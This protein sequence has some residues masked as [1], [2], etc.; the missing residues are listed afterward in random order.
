IPGLSSG[1]ADPDGVVGIRVFSPLAVRPLIALSAPAALDFAGK[2]GGVN[3]PVCQGAKLT[4]A[5]FLGL[6]RLVDLHWNDGFVGVLHEILRQL[7]AVDPAFLADGVCHIFLLEQKVA[8]ISDISEDLPY[9]SVTEMLSLIGFYT[10]LGKLLFCGLRRQTV[11]VI[12]V[13]EPNDFCLLLMDDQRS[14]EH[15]SELQSRF[16]LVCR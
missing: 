6:H 3:A 11:H 12:V 13:D 2:A 14:E 5:R 7:P 1:T 15:T 4:T 8:R 16:D 9:G 10:H